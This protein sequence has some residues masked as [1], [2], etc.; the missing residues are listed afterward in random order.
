MK[1]TL[2]VQEREKGQKRQTE[3]LNNM[4]SGIMFA[5]GKEGPSG[6]CILP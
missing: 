2:V 1:N 4:Y 6:C 5:N 3:N